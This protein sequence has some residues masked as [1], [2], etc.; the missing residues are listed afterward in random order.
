MK[1]YIC[2]HCKRIVVLNAFTETVCELCG[3]NIVTSHI[4]G[5]KVCNACSVKNSVCM[6]CGKELKEDDKI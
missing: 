6:Q 1:D 3:E 2:E 5:H 4:P